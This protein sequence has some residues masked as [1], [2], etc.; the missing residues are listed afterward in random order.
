M[1]WFLRQ[2]FRG[3]SLAFAYAQAGQENSFG[4]PAMK[5]GLEYQFP[6]LAK[7]RDEGALRVERLDESGEWFKR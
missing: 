6:L 4:W 2:N 3:G 5:A 7:L 1:D